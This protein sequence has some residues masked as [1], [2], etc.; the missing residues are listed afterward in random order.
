MQSDGNRQH[1]DL[2]LKHSARRLAQESILTNLKTFK[3]CEDLHPGVG[4]DGR[5]IQ[6]SK[7]LPK[8]MAHRDPSKSSGRIPLLPMV[9]SP[10]DRLL[11]PYHRFSFETTG[12]IPLSLSSE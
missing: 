2:R 10:E 4:V 9:G 5:S 7:L 6:G 12:R 11:Q 3:M 8:W 1:Q